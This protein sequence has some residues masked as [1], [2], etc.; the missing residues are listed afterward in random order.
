MVSINTYYAPSCT[1][2]QATIFH[3]ATDSVSLFPESLIF[4]DPADCMCSSLKTLASKLENIHPIVESDCIT[5]RNC[6]GVRCALNISA[7]FSVRYFGEVVVLPCENALEFLVE[8]PDQETLIEDRF[9]GPVNESK[10]IDIGG[11]QFLA[12][13]LIKVMDYSLTAEVGFV[14]VRQV[15]CTAADIVNHV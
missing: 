6:T 5:T 11:F 8:K 13:Q 15:H 3:N 9:Q 4:L 1:C 10:I 14:C 7:E 2:I 12:G